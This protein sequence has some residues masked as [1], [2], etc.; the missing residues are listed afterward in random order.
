[1]S[2]T[3][4][5]SDISF[6]APRGFTALTFTET[7]LLL[8][9]GEDGTLR[10]YDLSPSAQRALC[11]AI[12][13]LPDEVS[14]IC[15]Q[16][17]KLP[18]VAAGK[19][20]VASGK[21]ILLF[22]LTSDKLLIGSQEAEEVVTLIEGND[23]EDNVLNQKIGV[24]KD[25]IVYSCDSGAVGV[26]DIQTKKR[27]VMKAMHS[28]V[29]CCHQYTLLVIDCSGD[30]QKKAIVS[31]GYDSHLLHFD[32]STGSVLS[33]LDISTHTSSRGA[34]VSLAPPFLYSVTINSN[35]VFTAGTA[36]GNVLVGRGGERGRRDR[37]N[38]RKWNGL[39]A[40]MVSQ[41]HIAEGPVIGVAW[42]GS[43]ELMSV[44]LLGQVKHL[45]LPEPQKRSHVLSHTDIETLWETR[46]TKVDKV[47]SLAVFETPEHVLHIA[48]GGLTSTG[49]GCIEIWKRP[50]KSN[51]EL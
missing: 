44:T 47:E 48:I 2:A 17:S 10:V 30:D 45:R 12:N 21:Q 49:R 29:S 40:D 5:G 36:D 42:V 26:Y 37:P 16:P 8:A 41:Y 51:T 7:G 46:T 39:S 31:G 18:P 22:D 15:C 3:E 43:S 19:A 35:G 1:M 13:G 32:I 11:K 24:S 6:E 25:M 4:Y 9:G 34:P 33:R 50:L 20:W 23:A 28:S 14:S 38:R 27:R